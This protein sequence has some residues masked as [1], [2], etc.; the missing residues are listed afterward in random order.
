MNEVVLFF[1]HSDNYT[2]AMKM[3]PF[4]IMLTPI[5]VPKFI[6]LELYL[7]HR[8][9]CVVNYTNKIV[10]YFHLRYLTFVLCHSWTLYFKPVNGEMQLE[11][12]TNKGLDLLFV[13]LAQS[14]CFNFNIDEI[15][16]INTASSVLVVLKVFMQKFSIDFS[17]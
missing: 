17:I 7:C 10:F 6:H 9:V 3:R 15:Y 11:K 8:Y 4:N 12:K 2:I 13:L 5:K 1:S 14:N 16:P